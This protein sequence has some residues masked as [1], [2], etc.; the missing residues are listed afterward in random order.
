[1]AGLVVP[2]NWALEANYPAGPN[3]WNGQPTKVQPSG[4][5]WIPNTKAAAE[6][7]NYLDNAMCNSLVSLTAGL[8]SLPAISWSAQVAVTS[9]PASAN[10]EG[11]AI[12]DPLNHLW[13]IGVT[14][15][16]T[17]DTMHLYTASGLGDPWVDR[18]G[19]GPVSAAGG[20]IAG[21][22][23]AE[24]AVNSSVYSLS[25][26]KPGTNA[27]YHQYLDGT[28]WTI[29]AVISSTTI[30]RLPIIP[31]YPGA[32]FISAVADTATAGNCGIYTSADSDGASTWTLRQAAGTT[33]T[34]WLL[35]SNQVTYQGETMAL[36]IPQNV[37]QNTYWSTTNGTTWTAQ[38]LGGLLP[39][40]Y[41]PTALA[42]ASDSL[43]SGWWLTGDDGSNHKKIL[44]SYDGINWT[45]VNSLTAGQTEGMT[46]MGPL[47]VM[48]I[49]SGAAGSSSLLVYSTDG[50]ITWY[51]SPAYLNANGTAPR[52]VKSTVENN[53]SQLFYH[54][55]LN[56]R[57][58]IAAG[59][60][61]KT[62][63]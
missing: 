52:W 19:A 7:R 45:L 54:H 51:Q 10:S 25:V 36:A 35:K 41:K 37:G 9:L 26:V 11:A 33:A 13:W 30:A 2:P 38:S 32:C 29:G 55:T 40:P 43:G 31:F 23:Q 17:P 34:D 44:K 5:L 4:D 8:A 21:L 56:Q 1:M 14:V 63:P 27:Q 15:P 61:L 60:A 18:S 22:A 62:W 58:S 42:W 20:F 12:W 59:F 28:G 6:E 50:G 24:T 49:G 48:T 39:S 3:L 47:L 53:G 57:F 16:G 46:G